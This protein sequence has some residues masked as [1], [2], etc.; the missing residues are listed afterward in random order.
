MIVC[1]CVVGEYRCNDRDWQRVTAFSLLV[2]AQ[3]RCLC[4][5]LHGSVV[6]AKFRSTLLPVE[7]EAYNALVVVWSGRTEHAAYHERDTARIETE[8]A[9][10]TLMDTSSL[11]SRLYQA[12]RHMHTIHARIVPSCVVSART[13][14][15]VLGPTL[16]AIFFAVI[17]VLGASNC[18]VVTRDVFSFA[19]ETSVSFPAKSTSVLCCLVDTV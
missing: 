8:R 16:R 19:L 2:V 18:L 5:R 6:P 9:L 15:V 3:S 4:G 7:H 13:E 10:V 1:S 11:D 17:H 14:H 12:T